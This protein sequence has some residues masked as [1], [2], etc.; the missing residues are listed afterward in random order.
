M[1]KYS[2]KI[3]N[4]TNNLSIKNLNINKSIFINK[5]FN[6]IKNIYNPNLNIPNYT[7]KYLKKIHDIDNDS[8]LF[9]F[10]KLYK[11]NDIKSLNDFVKYYIENNLT[12]IDIIKENIKDNTSLLNKFN[13]IY[14]D[15]DDRVEIKNIFYHNIFVS[16][17]ILHELESFDLKYIEIIDS[18]FILKLYYYDIDN[19]DIYIRNIINIINIIKEINNSLHIESVKLYNVILFLGNQKKY[20]F[21]NKI[22]PMNMNSGSTI[23]DVYVSVWRKEE[24]EKVLIHELCHYISIDFDI[25]LNKKINTDINSLFN[26]EGLNHVSESYNE[27]VAGIINMCYKSI[28]LNI[29]L[30]QIYLIETKFLL[31]QT[32]KLINFFGGSK[33]YDIFTMKIYQN[34]SCLSYIIL[35]FILFYN[36]N[37][38]MNILDEFN[39][40]CN[41]S[42]KINELNTFLLE[43]IIKK[44]YITDIDKNTNFVINNWN[45]KFV[46]KTLR[47][48]AI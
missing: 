24:Y 38:F 39:I 9:K 22:S 18:Y 44:D 16:I 8:L 32:I 1:D 43:I 11:P 17:D 21:G 47:M 46:Y 12:E 36:L 25:Y 45:N 37:D 19:I 41:S 27:T 14:F 2:L 3:K 7:I 6:I 10:Y 33:G 20:L 30:N 13:K 15:K 48:S 4:I 5:L 29:D 23:K 40:I 26:L 35:K 34:T 28:K 31:F 42:K